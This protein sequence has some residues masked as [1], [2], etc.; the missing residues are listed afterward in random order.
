MVSVSALC[1]K[2]SVS[3]DHKVMLTFFLKM[4]IFCFPY[5]FLIFIFFYMDNHCPSTIY[6]TVSSFP[7]DL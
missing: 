2:N 6:Q 3:L 4:L 5:L 1:L 7:T